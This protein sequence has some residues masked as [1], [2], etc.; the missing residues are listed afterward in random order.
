M[1]ETGVPGFVGNNRSAA[2]VKPKFRFTL[3]SLFAVMTL[4]ALALSWFQSEYFWY[5]VTVV[6]IANLAGLLVA[7]FLTKVLK[8]PTDGGHWQQEIREEGS[9]ASQNDSRP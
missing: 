3:F 7:L 4:V 8:M 2:N 6:V 5:V 1:A 9:Q